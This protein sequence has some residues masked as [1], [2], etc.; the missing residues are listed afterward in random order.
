MW[1]MVGVPGGIFL[2]GPVH[3]P[4]L[5]T[6]VL[7]LL[8]L[9][10]LVSIP[11][12]IW[13]L[14]APSRGWLGLWVMNVY[15]SRRIIENSVETASRNL[16]IAATADVV[17]LPP[18][19]LK[20]ATRVWRLPDGSRIWLLVSGTQ[21]ADAESEA[22]IELYMQSDKAELSTE[23]ERFMWE[24][25]K[26]L[27][28]DGM[29]L[30]TQGYMSRPPTRTQ[31]ISSARENLQRIR[32]KMIALV[33]LSFY[34]TAMMLLALLYIPSELAVPP[35]LLLLTPAVIICSAAALKV[36][37]YAKEKEKLASME[38]QFVELD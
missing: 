14:Y 38:D 32:W 20:R 30:D 22:V 18:G 1:A 9:L 34:V 3:L 24:I 35:R 4:L 36:R 11:Y 16:G 31:V 7:V 5:Q 27:R 13:S 37:Q 6:S 26:E 25:G 29:A 15:G 8:N 33:V 2:F 21:A 17:R 10:F 12:L 23:A 19:T 28:R